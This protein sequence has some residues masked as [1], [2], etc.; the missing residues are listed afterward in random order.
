MIHWSYN[1]Y[2]THC[3]HSFVWTNDLY[4]KWQIKVLYQKHLKVHPQKTDNTP[5]KSSLN[6]RSEQN[7]D[8]CVLCQREELNPN[9]LCLVFK[10]CNAG[11]IASKMKLFPLP[12]GATNKQSCPIKTFSS[13]SFWCCLIELYPSFCTLYCKASFIKLSTAVVVR[14]KWLNTV[15]LYDRKETHTA[16]TLAVQKSH[17]PPVTIMLAPGASH[18]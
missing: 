9:Y 13:I 4:P 3:F 2:Y 15:T 1:I 17:Y 11:G 6:I 7:Y 12:V 5:R 10:Y 8:L 18:F 14:V 16:A